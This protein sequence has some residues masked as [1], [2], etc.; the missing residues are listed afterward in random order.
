MLLGIRRVRTAL[1]CLVMLASAV[2]Q[3]EDTYKLEEPVDDIRIF[4]VGTRV[5]IK[6]KVQLAP[7]AA[8]SPQSVS[9]ALSYRERRM[10]GPGNDAE[11]F[12]S[13]R[14]YETAESQI[15]VDG[16]KSSARLPDSSKL[17]VAQGRFDRVELYSL[18]GLLTEN[19]LELIQSP[20][21]SLALISLLPSK[22][23]S[24]GEKWTAPS[25]AFQFLTSVDAVTKGELA[26]SLESVEKGIAKVKITGSLEGAASAATTEIKIN[27]FYSYNLEKKHIADVDFVQMETRAVGPI[28]PGLELTARVRVLRSPSNASGR[29]ADQK[30]ID[31][32]A[33]TPDPKV[34]QLRF[35]SPWNIGLQY[36]RHWHLWRLEEKTVRFRLM[37]EGNFIA[38]CDW[39]PIPNAKPGTHLAEQTYLDDIRH[40]LGE[41]LISINQGEV[42][43]TSDKRFVYKVIAHGTVGEKKHTW[44]FYLIAD[45]SGRQVS[46]MFTVETSLAETLVKYD[47][48][49]V[50]SIKIGPAPI[51]R[52]AKN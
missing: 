9:A 50:D 44:I 36:G 10:L 43:P 38:Q 19:E 32:A 35:E 22:E 46:M 48:E 24:V 47:R 15:E 5:D 23:V 16:E 52:S 17:V 37:E 49:L 25:W 21:D 13:I 11:G 27:G 1:A 14:D 39:A 51:A 29:L 2:C 41:R 30:L 31:A 40:S 45:Q 18:N 34:L 4:G 8:K 6:G 7:N 42:I 3:A 26:C 20:A 28:S 33:D 12:R